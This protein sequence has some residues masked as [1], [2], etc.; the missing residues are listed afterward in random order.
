MASRRR[1][2]RHRQRSGQR[3]LGTPSLKLRRER[4][5]ARYRR[6]IERLYSAS[7]DAPHEIAAE[8]TASL[9]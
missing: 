2:C 7:A 4:V 3:K 6:V 9:E 1:A 5:Y 8:S